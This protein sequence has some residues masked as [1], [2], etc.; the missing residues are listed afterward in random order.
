MIGLSLY[1]MDTIRE[2]LMTANRPF[3][4]TNAHGVRSTAPIGLTRPMRPHQSKT[5]ICKA[6]AHDQDDRT[7]F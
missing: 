2:T 6:L 7:S 5:L 4:K 3:T 1:A